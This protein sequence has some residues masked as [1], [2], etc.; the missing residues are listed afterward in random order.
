MSTWIIDGH[1]AAQSACAL[2]PRKPTS[3]KAQSV[4]EVQFAACRDG[5]ANIQPTPSLC[6]Y[7]AS[8]QSYLNSCIFFSE[9]LVAP[10]STAWS[11]YHLFLV[12]VAA[13][14]VVAG[15][16]SVFVADPV[17][18]VDAVRAGSSTNLSLLISTLMSC[19]PMPR[20]PPT[21]IT[22]PSTFPDLSTRTSLISPSFSFLSL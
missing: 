21:P 18:S 11:G 8:T 16:L 3:A 1:F 10:L 17:V 2:R 12:V 19:W 20:K 13:V 9:S 6:W 14:V 4:A 15:R 22:T 5:V 7:A